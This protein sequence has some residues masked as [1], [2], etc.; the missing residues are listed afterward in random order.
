MPTILEESDDNMEETIFKGGKNS[1]DPNQGGHY[2]SR[3]IGKFLNDRKF[4]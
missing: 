3:G 4:V 1:C 2:G